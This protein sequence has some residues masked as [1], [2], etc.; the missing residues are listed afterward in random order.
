MFFENYDV[1]MKTVCCRVFRKLKHR[2]MNSW[3]LTEYYQ[4]SGNY[5][6]VKIFKVMFFGTCRRKLPIF[7]PNWIKTW[8]WRAMNSFYFD[9]QL[10]T[11]DNPFLLSLTQT[12]INREKWVILK[13]REIM[14]IETQ[15]Q[16]TWKNF[17]QE[18][19]RNPNARF[20][21]VQI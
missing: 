7:S 21:L 5:H 11:R 16:P 15:S 3:F 2:S 1:W 8:W 10:I 19:G 20:W 17:H 12:F 9:Y 18:Y 6:E 4:K 14:E 13:I